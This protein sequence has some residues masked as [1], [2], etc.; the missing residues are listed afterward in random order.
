[1]DLR[2]QGVLVLAAAF[3]FLGAAP[4]DQWEDE[5]LKSPDKKVFQCYW[6]SQKNH[7][8][9]GKGGTTC[10]DGGSYGVC[11]GTTESSCGCQP[12]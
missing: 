8:L 7:C 4:D 11:E 9:N 6:D 2:Y 10:K 5:E 1:M 12:L 3:F